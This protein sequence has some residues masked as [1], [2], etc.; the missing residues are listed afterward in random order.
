MATTL[1]LSQPAIEHPEATT[2]H[3]ADFSENANGDQFN[4][5]KF[6]GSVAHNLIIGKTIVVTGI[7]QFISKK[8]IFLLPREI[9]NRLPNI[10]VKFILVGESE[11]LSGWIQ[12]FSVE[13]VTPETFQPEKNVPLD[14]EVKYT[15]GLTASFDNYKGH[16]TLGYN[17][18]YE[19]VQ[20]V[21]ETNEHHIDQQYNGVLIR[22]NVDSK[23]GGFIMS[24]PE[25]GPT[26]HI[27][28]NTT[29]RAALSGP[30]V[31]K[32]NSEVFSFSIL[33]I[34]STSKRDVPLTIAKEKETEVTITGFYQYVLS[35]SF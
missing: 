18:T 25:I 5:A 14:V 16:I 28:V 12:R 17:L 15:C 34:D 19:E 33:D 35:P 30:I 3:I 9:I 1:Y 10:K 32:Y 20:E 29:I 23:A 13:C 27:T 4:Q 6:F 22:L 21:K 31:E 26:S 24:V 8:G 7:E 11:K 2:M